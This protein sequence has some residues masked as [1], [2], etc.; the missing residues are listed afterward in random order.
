MCVLCVHVCVVCVCMCAC[1][2]VCSLTC[3]NGGVKEARALLMEGF[4]LLYLPED[5][6]YLM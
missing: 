6:C 3:I 4:V 2:C 5:A 1:V